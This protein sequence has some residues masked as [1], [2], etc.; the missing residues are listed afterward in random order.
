MEDRESKLQEILDNREERNKYLFSEE[1]MP[2]CQQEK[3][4][5]DAKY[6][7]E[8]QTSKANLEMF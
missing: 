1:R 8:Y 2:D 7:L 5:Q 3:K 6:K 4:K